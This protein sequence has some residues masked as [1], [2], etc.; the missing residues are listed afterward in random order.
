[1]GEVRKYDQIE[2]LL[3]SS[4]FKVDVVRVLVVREV[5]VSSLEARSC[6]RHQRYQIDD[7]KFPAFLALFRTPARIRE[8]AK[9]D[10]DPR[11][12]AIY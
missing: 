2:S 4:Q 9:D 1:M 11:L 3:M 12:Q 6:L 10:D 5:K 7:S 8:L